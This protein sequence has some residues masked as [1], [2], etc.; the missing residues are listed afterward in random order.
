LRTL[1][2]RVLGATGVRTLLLLRAGT[3][4]LLGTAATRAALAHSTAAG[5]KQDKAAR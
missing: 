4:L 1:L 3:G 5:C 2:L